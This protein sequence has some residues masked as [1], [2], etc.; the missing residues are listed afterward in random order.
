MR[1]FSAQQYIV[2]CGLPRSYRPNT[3][4]RSRYH[5]CCG[6]AI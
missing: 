5:C 6:K 4:P 3:E 2:I 1:I